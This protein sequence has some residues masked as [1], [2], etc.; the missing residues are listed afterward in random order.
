[1]SRPI[2]WFAV[3][4]WAFILLVCAVFLVFLAGLVDELLVIP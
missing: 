3:F 4:W 2:D 1:M